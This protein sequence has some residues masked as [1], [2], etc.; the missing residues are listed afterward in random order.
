MHSAGVSWSF[1][2]CIPLWSPFSLSFLPYYKVLLSRPRQCKSMTCILYFDES[3]MQYKPPYSEQCLISIPFALP[4]LLSESF[5][6]A[7]YMAIKHSNAV[8]NPWEGISRKP[9]V[10]KRAILEQKLIHLGICDLLAHVFLSGGFIRST[11]YF[12]LFRIR[13]Q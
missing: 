6:N 5:F 13:I 1:S 10:V 3:A 7:M 11:W 9:S 12:G 8:H 4:K 2:C